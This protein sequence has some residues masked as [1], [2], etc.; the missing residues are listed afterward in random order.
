MTSSTKTGIIGIFV[1]VL[2][3]IIGIFFYL[4]GTSGGGAGNGDS[5]N[6]DTQKTSNVKVQETVRQTPPPLEAIDRVR[7]REINAIF[8]MTGKASDADWGIRGGANF[9]YEVTIVAES[10]IE[11]KEKMDGGGFKVEEIRTFKKVHDSVTASD[12]D[13]TLALDTLPISTIQGIVAVG[14]FFWPVTAGTAVLGLEKM[15]EFDGK[16]IKDALNALGIELPQEVKKEIESFAGGELRKWMGKTRRISGKSY[17]I[18]YYNAE[19]GNPMLITFRNADGS[20]VT[21]EEELMLLRRANA[22]VNS[23]LLPDTN[24]KPGDKWSVKV[25]DMQ[26]LLDPY[27]EG[28]FAG[29]VTVTRTADKKPGEW[30]LDLS[31]ATIRVLSPSGS[32]TGTLNLE[33]GA[34][35]VELDAY[36]VNDL[37]LS[38]TGNL[39]KLSKHHLLFNARF[40]GACKFQGRI[41]TKLLSTK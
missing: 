2:I 7:S 41:T 29:S 40:D 21:D 10:T 6:D 25:E 32:T 27:V 26:E 34:A 15:K 9:L 31:P 30:S 36:S 39:S 28:D 22:F 5:D 38:G 17:R 11:S 35:Q 3:A 8:Q 4:K 18:T 24:C 33:E 37:I 16:G 1:G 13:F 23:D 19:S 20:E 14:G 12:V